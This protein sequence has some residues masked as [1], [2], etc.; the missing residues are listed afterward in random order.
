MGHDTYAPKINRRR[1]YAQ[2][3]TGRRHTAHII[4]LSGLYRGRPLC[5]MSFGPG[6]I[7]RSFDELTETDKICG[8]CQRL[9]VRRG[10]SQ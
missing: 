2:A 10:E 1:K 4:G 5:G 7:W 8:F 9:H 6:A 3:I